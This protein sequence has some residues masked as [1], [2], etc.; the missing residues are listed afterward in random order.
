MS[1]PGLPVNIDATYPDSS[2]DPS[3]KAHQQQHDVIHRML[4]RLDNVTP[5]VVGAVLSWDGSLWTPKANITTAKRPGF[6]TVA[7]ANSPDSFKDVADYVCDGVA[8]QNE[9]NI[10]IGAAQP[11]NGSTAGSGGTVKLAPGVFNDSG[12]IRGRTWV[13]LEGSGHLATQVKA[14]A[15]WSSSAGDG[16]AV[17]GIWEVY[18]RAVQ[19]SRVEN[20]TLHGQSNQVHGVHA[21]ADTALAPRVGG[22]QDSGLMCRTLLIRNVVTGLNF[23]RGSRANHCKDI[24]ILNASGV[25]VLVRCVD[26]FWEGVETGSAGSHGFWVSGSNHRFVD[27]K[28]WYSDGHG[29][30][31]TGPRNAGSGLE[32]Q[33][34]QQHGFFFDAGDSTFSSILSDSNSYNGS[35][36]SSPTGYG[37]YDGIRVSA[38]NF[39]LHGFTCLD[40]NESGRGYRQRAGISIDAANSG[41]LSIHG[42]CRDSGVVA[43]AGVSTTAPSN[44]ARNVRI[45]GTLH[46]NEHVVILCRNNGGQRYV[47]AQYPTTG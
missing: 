39:S 27:C 36:V 22:H 10:A 3:V 32:A 40:K 26:S 21:A 6:L 38:Y 13:T 44:A 34:N 23:P 9:I 25:A 46:A 37:L 42:T 8:D 5:S 41:G 33:D 31:F 18:D 14:T 1:G 35:S 24:R 15:G 43:G 30:Y 47:F 16:A 20:L 2:S 11:G 29:W 45:D 12:P 19:F 4:N 7:A 17:G 28:S